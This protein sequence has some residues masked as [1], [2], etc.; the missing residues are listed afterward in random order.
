LLGTFIGLQRTAA[1]LILQLVLNLSNVALDLIFV[2]VMG[3]GITGVALASVISECLALLCGLALLWPRLSSAIQQLSIDTLLHLPS[4]RRLLAINADIFL[5]TLLL[6]GSTFYL[7]AAATRMGE[8]VLAANAILLQLLHLCAYTLDGFAHAAETLTGQAFGARDR[9]KLDM[10]IR[11]STLQATI[12]AFFLMLLLWFF[13]DIGIRFF[14]DQADVIQQ[15]LVVLP[16]LIAMPLVSVWSY[17]LDGIF[18]GTTHTR[19]MR[20][21]MAISALCFVLCAELLQPRLGNHGL[22]LAFT[23]FSLCRA[24]TLLLYLPAIRRQTDQTA[25]ATTS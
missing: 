21:G 3:Y 14:T 25:L 7:N 9:K 18:I 17:Q 6:V 23:C 1:V 11:I 19:Q 13:G 12:L 24:I 10:A 22:W 2:V 16:W 20:N 5:R 8:V 4:I 15:A